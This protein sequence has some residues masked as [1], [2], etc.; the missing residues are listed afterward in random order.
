MN[1]Q[2]QN[3]R[4]DKPVEAFLSVNSDRFNFD[5]WASEVRRQMLA[6][7]QKRAVKGKGKFVKKK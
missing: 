7:L 6:S 3:Q 5:L 2:L 1:L 4:K